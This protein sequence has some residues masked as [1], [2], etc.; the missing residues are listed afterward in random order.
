M[1]PQNIHLND[2]VVRSS[3]A[4]AEISSI[5]ITWT[6]APNNTTQY[7]NGD[8]TFNNTNNVYYIIHAQIDS[9]WRC[10]YNRNLVNTQKSLVAALLKVS[11]R[12]RRSI[13]RLTQHQKQRNSYLCRRTIYA[14]NLR[15]NLDV[16]HGFELDKLYGEYVYYYTLSPGQSYKQQTYVN[17]PG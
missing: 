4:L 10:C 17:H 7:N 5:S 1:L 3:T 15:N 13:L 14:R 9:F 2:A 6:W 16:Q 12:S 8:T 11:F